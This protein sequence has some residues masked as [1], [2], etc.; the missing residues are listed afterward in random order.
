VGTTAPAVLT[1]NETGTFTFGFFASD[2]QTPT[3]SFAADG[4]ANAPS[5]YPAQQ[6]NNYLAGQPGAMPGRPDFD[7]GGNTLL[8]AQM[9]SQPEWDGPPTPLVQ[10]GNQA[11]APSAAA[12]IINTYTIP[13]SNTGTSGQWQVA[14]S[15]TAAVGDSGFWGDLCKFGH[16]IDHAIRKGAMAVNHVVVDVENKIVSFTMQLANGFTQVLQLVIN[17]VHDVVSAVKAVFRSIG[18]AVDDAIHWPQ[19]TVQLVRH[20]QYKEGA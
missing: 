4:L 9:Q 8:N 19:V 3:F 2:L 14:P 5:I 12:S 11:N 17:T 15:Q 6:V 1:T 16:D 18:R 13:V 10:S 7:S 20:S